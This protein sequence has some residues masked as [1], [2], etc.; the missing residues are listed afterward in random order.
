MNSLNKNI[1][2]ATV[3]LIAGFAAG[4][5]TRAVSSGRCKS[6][7]EAPHYMLSHETAKRYVNNYGSRANFVRQMRDGRAMVVRNP[8]YVWFPAWRIKKFLCQIEQEG[9]NG[10]RFYF[11]T[12]DSTYAGYDSNGEEPA[13]DTTFWGRNTLLFVSTKKIN[14]VNTDYFPDEKNGKQEGFIEVPVY[15]NNGEMCPPPS[16]C[17]AKGALLL[18]SV[19]SRL[20]RIN[21]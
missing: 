1:L 18:D 10:I 5:F 7:T 14:G 13:P 12:Y 9:G 8:R 11:A 15:E 4:Y 16:N 6:P 2:I 20:P 3:V 17:L 21:L 19:A